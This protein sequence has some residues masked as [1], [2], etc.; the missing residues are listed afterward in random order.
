MKRDIHNKDQR[1]QTAQQQVKDYTLLKKITKRVG[2]VI[3][4]N[5]NCIFIP[6]F[7]S[8]TA[9]G[10]GQKFAAF[11]A[12]GLLKAHHVLLPHLTVTS[13]DVTADPTATLQPLTA[14][15]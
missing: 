14:V 15:H 1:L 2:L 11:P 6:F 12:A 3:S 9:P 5:V 13:T 4:I 7:S 10:E 8:T